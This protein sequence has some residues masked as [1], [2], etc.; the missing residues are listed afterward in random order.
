M[1]DNNQNNLSNV[2]YELNKVAREQA[3]TTQSV[4]RL[5]FLLI[6]RL[7]TMLGIN[8]SDRR[9]QREMQKD[10]DQIQKAN[11]GRPGS[12]QPGG[13]AG[14]GSPGFVS[15]IGIGGLFGLGG[16]AA[17]AGVRGLAGLATTRIGLTAM[18]LGV[19]AA[20]LSENS[21]EYNKFSKD[22]EGLEKKY[23]F[24][25]EDIG[26]KIIA[27][28][29]FMPVMSGI[30]NFFERLK[31][32][33]NSKA[34]NTLAAPVGWSL[35]TLGGITNIGITRLAAFLKEFQPLARAF[36]GFFAAKSAVQEFKRQTTTIAPDGTKV[37]FDEA[38][39]S[40]LG[41]F[42]EEY[43]NYI[44]VD[45][46]AFIFGISSKFNESLGMDGAASA[47]AKTSEIIE[48]LG[49]Q[50][51]SFI[52]D[53]MGASYT[54]IK[55]IFS[56]ESYKNNPKYIEAQHRFIAGLGSIM[57]ALWDN[58]IGIFTGFVG[59]LLGV[60]KKEIQMKGDEAYDAVL[61]IGGAIEQ[62]GFLGSDMIGAVTEGIESGEVTSLADVGRMLGES[63]NKMIIGIVTDPAQRAE[64]FQAINKGIT[65]LAFIVLDVFKAIGNYALEKLGLGEDKLGAT[66]SKKIKVIEDF[67]PNA[68]EGLTRREKYDYVATSE[69]I[70]QFGL[71]S[72]WTNELLK[73]AANSIVD[74]DKF[75]AMMDENIN[76]ITKLQ[77][78]I[79][80]KQITFGDKE[81]IQ[82]M[83]NDLNNLRD[84]NRK[85]ETQLMV[86][87]SSR[88]AINS[89]LSRTG[90]YN[91]TVEDVV[92]YLITQ[93]NPGSNGGNSNQKSPITPNN[94]ASRPQEY[95][96][97]TPMPMGSQTDDT[98]IGP[99]GYRRFRY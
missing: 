94:G 7:D 96:T 47:F 91:L 62:L 46:L 56:D 85:L 52:P 9:Y 49:N 80:S 13:L 58:T 61:G 2:T 99:S 89:I 34:F 39:V 12:G 65:D 1:P 63:L 43:I 82:R 22:L 69:G 19:M 72:L 92:N 70:R 28:E 54:L 51:T 74:R 38:G 41:T 48:T 37:T 21:E 86:D 44:F 79:I 5:S 24:S 35:N 27:F 10:Y 40:A 30:G 8:K 16:G 6:D 59:G 33:T 11:R 73:R 29:K 25:I 15:G 97:L 32:V 88:E 71:S 36:G 23:S 50:F 75:K 77:A 4:D 93:N 98:L 81:T 67:N 55:G 45:P 53:F 95:G 14:P 66:S 68:M 3:A 31:I 57:N 60:P 64:F 87:Q 18:G 83:R 20:I 78:A 84:E 17:I 26:V 76:T 42:I 90:Q